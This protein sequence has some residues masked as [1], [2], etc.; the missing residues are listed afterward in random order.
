MLIYLS[1][2][3]T[4]LPDLGR[5]TFNRAEQELRAKGHNVLNPA[6]LPTD[7]PESAYLPI[8]MAMLEQAEAIYLLDGWMKSAGAI[9]EFAYAERQKKRVLGFE[10]PLGVTLCYSC[11][12]EE[13]VDR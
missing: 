8:C 13:C 1:G 9:A 3:M 4:G 10:S 11:R 7:L 5:E 6:C 2:P 12:T